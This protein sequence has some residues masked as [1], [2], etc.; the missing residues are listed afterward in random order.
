MF[1]V[2]QLSFLLIIFTHVKSHELLFD[3][4]N[5]EAQNPAV[6]LTE[7]CSEDLSSITNGIKNNEIW[8]I[9][10]R[11]ASGKS[12]ADF[13]WGNNFWLGSEKACEFLN[14]PKKIPQVA[15]KTRRSGENVTLIASKVPVEYR[16]F[17]ATHTSPIQF[18]TETYR[19][20]GL[21]IGICFPKSCEESE[22]IEM[23]RIIF[24]SGEFDQPVI[25]GEVNF[26]K[27]KNLKLRADFFKD[28]FTKA[29]G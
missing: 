11:D 15:T 9:K 22:I 27:T 2:L 13:I 24:K 1:T 6:K 4:L 10:V 29:L 26:V 23:S 8:A 17:Y 5:F 14:H 16:M 21:Q 25:Y 19:Y 18:D 28:P 12:S 7:K 20:V 3:F